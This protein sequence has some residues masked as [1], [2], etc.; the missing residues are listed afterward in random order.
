MRLATA[1]DGGMLHDKV[2]DIVR[3]QIHQKVYRPGDKLPS[4]RQLHH[5]LGVS[6]TTVLNAYGVLETE[7]WIGSEPKSGFYVRLRQM[8][9]TPATT[10]PPKRPA[11]PS[12]D[13]F[14]LG[15]LRD[16]ARGD[17]IQLATA[18]PNPEAMPVATLTRLIRSVSTEYPEEA[19][20]Y[21]PFQGFRPLREQIARRM[22]SAGCA[23]APDQILI[24][25]GCG[26]AL[27][28][29]LR[30]ICKPGDVVAIE[31]P[32]YFA[33]LQQ[34]RSM[35]LRVMEVATS[36][37]HGMC[38]DALEEV[39]KAD[40]VS[41]VLAT[42][43]FNNPIGALMPDA[44]KQ[45]LVEMLSEYGVPLIEDDVYGELS[46]DEDRP[47]VCKAFDTKGM[48]VYCSSFSK[49]I[50]PGYR[51]G[52]VT[53]G[54]FHNDLVL[55]KFSSSCSSV[56]LQQMVLAE[57]LQNYR[58]GKIV[59]KATQYYKKNINAAI[60]VV[61]DAFPEG[62]AIV[63]PLGGFVLWIEMP[64]RCDSVELYRRASAQGILFIPGPGF[65]SHG[66][67]RN[68]FRMNVATWNERTEE[69]VRTLGR[70]AKEML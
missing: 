16:M 18:N 17:Q 51:V 50:A 2:A 25:A 43:N 36:K 11:G 9:P 23:I 56:S 61:Y 39:L 14:L 57:F 67:Y 33:L 24:T 45:R 15:I 63:E 66:L 59:H 20:S 26:E 46:F 34:L 31:S 62:T 53:G 19:A 10:D 5:Q 27:T 64:E 68:C 38:L 40:K 52:W 55:Q 48:V 22:I 41:A 29:A 7:G 8:R 30:V 32:A 1:T 70:M 6:I 65:S 44:K 4:V 28:L 42:P 12:S 69:A 54:V 37:K 35:G 60:K 21:A 13:P 3:T 49:T 47:S 58:Y